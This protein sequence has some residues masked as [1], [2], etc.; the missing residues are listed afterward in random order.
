MLT[1]IYWALTQQLSMLLARLELALLSPLMPQRK[2]CK[3]FSNMAELF[4][5][6]LECPPTQDFYLKISQTNLAYLKFLAL[7]ISLK[8]DPRKKRV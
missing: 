2:Y 7:Q 3:I 5:A 1:V 6:G 8:A 4:E